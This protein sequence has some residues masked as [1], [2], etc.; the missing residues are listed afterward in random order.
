MTPN[1]QSKE[2]HSLTGQHPTTRL[3]LTSAIVVLLGCLLASLTLGMYLQVQRNLERRT[4]F[5]LRHQVLDH[6]TPEPVSRRLEMPPHKPAHSFLSQLK[7]PLQL[8]MPESGQQAW[9]QISTPFVHVRYYDLHLRKVL[10]LG[11]PPERPREQLDELQKLLDSHKEAREYTSDNPIEGW[12]MWSQLVR[13]SSGQV[14]G[15]LEMGMGSKPSEELLHDLAGWLAVAGSLALLVGIGMAAVIARS[16]CR[17]LENIAAKMHS[18]S[19]GDFTVRAAQQGP[20]EMQTIA[21]TFNTM[22]SQLSQVFHSQRRF[23]A[24]ASHELK[25]PLT[26]V[27]TMVEVLR[28]HQEITPERK[29]RAFFVIERELNR[30]DQLVHDLLTL[31]RLDEPLKAP[32]RVDLR[33]LV[34][35]LAADYAQAYSNLQADCQGPPAWLDLVDPSGGERAIRNLLDNALAHTQEPARVV[36]RLSQQPDGMLVEV[37]D[38]GAGISPQD[39][40]HVTRRFY[41][42]DQSRS[43]L[44]GGSGL[45]LAIVSAWVTL[46]GGRLDL[47]S[48]LG[49]GTVVRMWLPTTA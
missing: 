29:Q 39:L 8:V 19:A 40:P 23:V 9:D 6:W 5:Q 21:A 2:T 37:A 15:V 46:N 25:T 16:V 28:D 30:V 3:L 10:E 41:R 26:S 44:S 24:D 12:L 4:L 48:A 27:Q 31:S 36:L 17:P 11:G 13:D 32:E 7:R 47:E 22:V 43:R 49:K 35:S 18:L 20:L 34:H 38:E 42:S 14:V 1:R 45:G 33:A